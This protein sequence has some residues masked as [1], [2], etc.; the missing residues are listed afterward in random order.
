MIMKFAEKAAFISFYPPWK[1]GIAT[2]TADLIANIILAS[3]GEFDTVICAMDWGDNPVY[4]D[5]IKPKIRKDVKYDYI[6]PAKQSQ[7][8]NELN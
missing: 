6:H 3:E 5:S 7:L 2:F 4:S 1:C 8:R